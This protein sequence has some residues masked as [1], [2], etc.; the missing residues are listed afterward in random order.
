MIIP[1]YM[2]RTKKGT[3]NRVSDAIGKAGADFK[4]E[5]TPDTYKAFFARAGYT[6][7]TYT[8]CEETIPCTVAVIRK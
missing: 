1:T 8:Q 7:V 4:T 6:D 5:F 3:A 2:N